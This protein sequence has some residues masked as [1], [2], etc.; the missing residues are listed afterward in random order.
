MDCIVQG[1][2]KSQTRLSGL[3]SLCPYS[4]PSFISW[5]CISEGEQRVT[6]AIIGVNLNSVLK[7]KSKLLT[8]L[9]V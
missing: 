5:E 9:P 8:D 6:V 1:V 3:H 7:R 2:T 4:G